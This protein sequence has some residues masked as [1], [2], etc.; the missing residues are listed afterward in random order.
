MK[1]STKRWLAAATTCAISAFAGWAGGYDFDERTPGV[2]F[3]IISTLL[4]ALV[5][6]TCPIFSD[7]F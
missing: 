7:D 5:V 1:S 2:A 3:W 4:I 6:A